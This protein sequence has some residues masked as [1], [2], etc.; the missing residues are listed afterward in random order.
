MPQRATLLI[1]PGLDGTAPVA[2]LLHGAAADRGTLARMA[3]AVAETGIP[4]LNASWAFDVKN[5]AEAAADAVCAVAYA[6]QH[7]SS[8]GADPDR[9]IVMGHSGGGHIVMLS[10]LAPEA[11][12]ECAT[13]SEAHVWAYI[14]MAGDPAAAAPGGNA[15]RFFEHDPELLKRMDNFSHVG[16]NSDL[17]ARF[18]HGTADFTVPIE[19]TRGFHDTLVAAGYDSE[20]IPVA[21]ADHFDPANPTTDAGLETLNQLQSILATLEP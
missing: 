13:A 9:V 3:E 16:S 14:G 12:P 4:V 21:A 20:L 6:N 17:I 7:A 15:R 11:F 10:A 2:V 5:P 1:P 8:W 18:V 19:L